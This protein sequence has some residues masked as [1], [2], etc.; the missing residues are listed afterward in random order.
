MTLYRQPMQK[1]FKADLIVLNVLKLT[2]LGAVCKACFFLFQ[3]AM[4]L[5][6]K[7]PLQACY[8][9]LY[10]NKFGQPCFQTTYI[11][12][13]LDLC[14]RRSNLHVCSPADMREKWQT[15]CV[16][17]RSFCP[18]D[19]SIHPSCVLD[20]QHSSGEQESTHANCSVSNTGQEEE[21]V[22]KK[23]GWPNL[24]TKSCS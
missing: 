13:L 23:H 11:I 3:S 18:I 2:N 15:H 10:V 19:Q 14:L 21:Y 17:E 12:L 22:V 9:Q 24:L 16:G 8:E 20:D 1:K 6:Q 4:C 5:F 7:N